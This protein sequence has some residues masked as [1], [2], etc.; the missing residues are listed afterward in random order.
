MHQ[1]PVAGGLPHPRERAL[2]REERVALRGERRASE[3]ARDRGLRARRLG[4]L[5]ELA[6]VLVRLAPERWLVRLGAIRRL[7]HEHDLA[8]KLAL[9]LVEVA[10][11]L[12]RRHDHGRGHGAVRRWRPRDGDCLHRQQAR[13][14]HARLDALDRPAAAEVEA[15]GA[16]V[17]ESPGLELLL[18]PLLGRAHR[19]RVRHAAAD[20][21]GEIS[22]RLR[23]LA[24]V[25]LFVDD[26]VDRRVVDLRAARGR[27]RQREKP[28]DVA[29]G[30]S[31]SSGWT[32][33]QYRWDCRG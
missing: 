33:P 3:A 13:R 2:A 7:V 17:L 10:L 1:T 29:H 24:L 32:A 28:D 18:R 5:V 12:H 20:A 30:E 22:G 23:Q 15:F 9:P 11:A 4:I 26:P 25:Q 19:R 31:P 14:Q 6:E 21:I 16:H 8:A 27:E